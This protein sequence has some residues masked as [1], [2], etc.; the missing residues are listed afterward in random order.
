MRGIREEKG[1]KIPPKKVKNEEIS[2]TLGWDLYLIISLII[3]RINWFFFPR[4]S[5]KK[6]KKK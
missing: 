3:S 5:F 2:V 6:K 4:F 1:E